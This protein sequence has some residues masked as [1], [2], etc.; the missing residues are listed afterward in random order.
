MD[1]NIPSI[2]EAEVLLE[3]S[4]QLNPGPWAAHSRYV[5]QAAKA[6]AGECSELDPDTACVLGCLHDIGRRFGVSGMRH[7]VDGHRYLTSIGCDDAARISLTHSYPIKVAASGFGGWDGTAEEL[8]FVQ[9]YLDRTEYTLYDRLIQLCDS[10]ALPTGFVLMEKRLVD[11]AM[12]YGFNDYA[13]P[14]WKAYFEIRDEFDRLTGGSIYR[15]L[16]DVIPN[17]FGLPLPV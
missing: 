9:A 2:E 15:L 10:L 11:V 6:I 17:T 3:E 16:P 14:K 12:R 5:A 4:E 1:L 7:V 13:I 8:Q